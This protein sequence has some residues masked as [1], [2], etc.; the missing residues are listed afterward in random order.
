MS[1]IHIGNL[2]LCLGVLILAS[3]CGGPTPAPVV[4]ATPTATAEPTYKDMTLSATNFLANLPPDRGLIT[5][6][7]VAQQK[8]FIVDIRQPEEYRQ[9]FIAGAVNIPLREARGYSAGVAGPGSAN[10]PRLRQRPSLGDRHGGVTNARLQKSQEPCRRH[11]R[12]ARSK[13]ANGH[14]AGTRPSVRRA[15]ACGRRYSHGARSLFDRCA[16][17]GLGLDHF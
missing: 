5:S 11:G 4:S 17:G 12:V 10:R 6:Q 1:R 2:F 3:G 15:A 13:I 7:D 14:P 8:P 16:P 9:G